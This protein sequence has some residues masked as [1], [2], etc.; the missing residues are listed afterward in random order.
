MK[1]IGKDLRKGKRM[2]KCIEVRKVDLNDGM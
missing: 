1:I 2:M